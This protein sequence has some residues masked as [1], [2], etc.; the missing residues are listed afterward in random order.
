MVIVYRCE[1]VLMQNF[2]HLNFI[3]EHLNLLPKESHNTDFSRVRDYFLNGW[4][5]NYRQ[6]IFVSE[7]LFPELNFLWK[8]HCAST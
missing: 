3:F 1:V 5:K 6:S 8:H 7:F 4:G 2:E